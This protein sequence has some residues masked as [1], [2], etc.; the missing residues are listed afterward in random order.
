MSEWSSGELN[1]NGIRVHYYRTGGDKPPV[2]LSHG[3]TDD[4]LCWTPVARVLAANYDVI[5]PD[6]RGHGLSEAP[7]NG[8]SS[9]ERAKDLAGLIESLRLEKPAVGGHSM[10]GQTTFRLAIER[11]D[12]IRCAILEDPGFRPRSTPEE[13]VG[14]QERSA[15]MRENVARLKGMNR[16][17]LLAYIRAERPTWSEDEYGPWADSKLRLSLK[18]GGAVRFPEGPMWWESL[19]SLTRPTLLITAD[20]DKGSIVTSE[21]AAEAARLSPLLKVAHLAGAGHNIRRE[22]FAGF[23]EI[24]QKFLA[25]NV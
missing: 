8:Y 3:A 23:L 14:Q 21:V 16:D 17:E 12:L 24:V 11:P 5:M 19:P 22:Q 25:Q 1:A 2:V 20:P 7:D 9:A 15:R 6:A 4:G 10:G 13:P 18:F